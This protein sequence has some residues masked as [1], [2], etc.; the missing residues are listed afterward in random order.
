MMRK[1]LVALAATVVTLAASV[2]T[3]SPAS[4][5]TTRQLAVQSAADYA[6]S[7]G[8]HAAISVI[9][10]QTGV[11]NTSGYST[12][13]MPS[14]SV[15]KVYMATYLLRTGQM[16]GADERL[17]WPMITQSSN[18]AFETLLREH[19]NFSARALW[20][21]IDQHYHFWRIGAPT[22]N[23]SCWGGTRI[24]A[25]GITRL[26]QKILADPVVRPWLLKAMRHYEPVVDGF[27]QA[28]GIPSV[29]SK[30]L[31]GIKQG[32]SNGCSPQWPYR[33][34]LNSTGIVY[35]RYAVAILTESTLSMSDQK[36]VISRMARM[37]LAPLIASNGTS[38]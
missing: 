12:N 16:Y 13:R 2:T 31:V 26:Y 30:P 33:T 4:A 15:V 29:L 24:T 34:V 22:P 38:A 3:M 21:W 6:S 5:L 14:A 9:D 19:F 28:F 20:N 27:N 10:T 11:M 17:A 25:R 23:S 8:V 7:H 1:S 18:Y 35:G 37:V 32:W 36:K